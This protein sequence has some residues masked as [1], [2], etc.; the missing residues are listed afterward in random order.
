MQHRAGFVNIVGRP[1]VGKSTLM[2]ALVGERMSII[3]SKPQ[4]TRRRIIGIVNADDFQIVFSDTPGIIKQPNYKMQAAMNHYVTTAFEDADLMIFL[5]D[6][7]DD[8]DGSE[9]TIADL[10]KLTC[11][12]FL[13]LI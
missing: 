9:H 1:N 2:N 12:R 10:K 4:T 7:E 5:I 6:V 8:W 3:T 11:P 13:V